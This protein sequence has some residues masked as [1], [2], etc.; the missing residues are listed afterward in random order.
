MGDLFVANIVAKQFTFATDFCNIEI[1]GLT[2]TPD[3]VANLRSFA[4]KYP[5]RTPLM[6]NDGIDA[7][8]WMLPLPDQTLVMTKSGANRLPFAVLLLFYRLHGRFPTTPE[9][10]DEAAVARI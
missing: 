6:A 10:I 7:G 5:S 9:E 1:P 3:F 4:T 8:A 2:G